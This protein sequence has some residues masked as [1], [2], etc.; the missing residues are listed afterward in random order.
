MTLCALKRRRFFKTCLK[1]I[2]KYPPRRSKQLYKDAA[3]TFTYT[4][5]GCFPS[6]SQCQFGTLN[7]LPLLAR[8]VVSHLAFGSSLQGFR[9]T[10]IASS[11]RWL[12][13]LAAH[14]LPL[15]AMQINLPA[16]F[17]HP[18]LKRR[19]YQASVLFTCHISSYR[20]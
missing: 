2:V 4:N 5:A 12:F 6:P 1:G 14:I 3:I 16:S 7:I 18:A 11:R 20:L 9:L 13:L 17:F 19:G 15:M 8:L 10:R